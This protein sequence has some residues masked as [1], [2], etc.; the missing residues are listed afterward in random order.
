MFFE[1]FTAR[2]S[3]EFDRFFKSLGHWNFGKE[4]FYERSDSKTID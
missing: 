1:D 2:L 3:E 4:N